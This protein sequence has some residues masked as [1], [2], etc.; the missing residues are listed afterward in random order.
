MSMSRKRRR[1]LIVAAIEGL[2]GFALVVAVILVATVLLKWA[3][4]L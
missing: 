3:G 2:I 4:V 1:E